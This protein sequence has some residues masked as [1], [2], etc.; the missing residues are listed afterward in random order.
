MGVIVVALDQ[1]NASI[2][3]VSGYDST[4][5]QKSAGW[6]PYD[7]LSRPADLGDRITNHQNPADAPQ[8][9]FVSLS[10]VGSIALVA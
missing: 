8:R 7:W 4:H 2:P 10:D 9:Q 6:A 1:G 5:R 3:A